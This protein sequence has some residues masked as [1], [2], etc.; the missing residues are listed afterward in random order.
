[1]QGHNKKECR[2]SNNHKGR[3]LAILPP[4][5]QIE[6]AKIKMKKKGNLERE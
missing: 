1:M 4:Q 6:I 3:V 2:I 5:Q